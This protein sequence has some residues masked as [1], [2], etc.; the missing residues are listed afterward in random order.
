MK[1]SFTQDFTAPP[2]RVF[3]ALLDPPTLQAALEGCEK[4]E[5]TA[6][7]RFD[8]VL[9]LGLAGIKGTYA[10]KVEIRDARPPE[11]LTIGFEGKGPG[12]F[13][14]GSARARLA[15]AP[16]GGTRLSAE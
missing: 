9:R 4:L 7:N 15:A 8:A 16:G 2:E 5:R 13:V 1:L 10:G 6:G 14:R 11:E 12:G 3:A